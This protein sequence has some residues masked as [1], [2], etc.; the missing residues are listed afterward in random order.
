MRGLSQEVRT[1]LIDERRI[2]QMEAVVAGA[3]RYRD[4][5]RQYMAEQTELIARGASLDE[6]VTSNWERFAETAAAEEELFALLD[7]LDADR[8]ESRDR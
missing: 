3:R 5:M 7:D 8:G 6:L 1:V 4:L 2:H